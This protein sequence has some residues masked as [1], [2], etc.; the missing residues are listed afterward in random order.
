MDLRMEETVA[1]TEDFNFTVLTPQSHADWLLWGLRMM[2][3]KGATN[4]ESL[5]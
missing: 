5:K 1:V 3:F 4:S 2:Y